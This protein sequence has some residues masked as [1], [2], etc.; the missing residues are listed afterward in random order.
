MFWQVFHR[1]TLIA[2]VLLTAGCA[3]TDP[4][5]ADGGF[6]KTRDGG[7]E[8]I[9]GFYPGRPERYYA[10][11]DGEVSEVYPVIQTPDRGDLVQVPFIVP[12]APGSS[13]MGPVAIGVLESVAQRM[14]S[15]PWNEV[16]IRGNTDSVGEGNIRR[17]GNFV[18]AEKLSTQRAVNVDRW[19]RKRLGDRYPKGKALVSGAGF[20]I[21]VVTG[22]LPSDQ[23]PNRRVDVRVI[24]PVG[25]K[26][27]G[28][29]YG[30]Q[31]SRTGIQFSK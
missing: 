2:S 22:G 17:A 16:F 21:P 24:E 28:Y 25:S 18:F 10:V 14:A 1:S 6:V 5:K 13:G 11:V 30:K 31:R 9:T 20:S 3:F 8:K 19:L 15:R 26:T 4:P 29:W 7:R 27:E 23:Q 12:F